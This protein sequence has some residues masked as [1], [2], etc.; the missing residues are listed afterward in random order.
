M[1]DLAALPSVPENCRNGTSRLLNQEQLMLLGN[2][3]KGSIF[4]TPDGL[5]FKHIKTIVEVASSISPK[6]FCH[7]THSLSERAHHHSGEGDQ[8]GVIPTGLVSHCA[9]SNAESDSPSA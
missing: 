2:T 9:S 6:F 5:G 7:F 3:I 1:N 8:H 4:D